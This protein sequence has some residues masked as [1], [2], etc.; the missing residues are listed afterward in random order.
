MGPLYAFPHSEG[1]KGRNHNFF[2]PPHTTHALA[3]SKGTGI[4]ECLSS[5]PGHV[6]NQFSFSEIFS[7][8]WKKAMIPST[9]SSG[10]KA[11]GVF[12]FNRAAV[13][14]AMDKKGCSTHVL[15]F[16]FVA[17]LPVDKLMYKQMSLSL[18]LQKLSFNAFSVGTNKVLTLQVTLDFESWDDDSLLARCV[19]S[20]HDP[21][22]VHHTPQP[23][24]TCTG[25]KYSPSPF[26]LDTY[27]GED[28]NSSRSMYPLTEGHGNRPS[29]FSQD[30][31]FPG[32]TGGVPCFQ[33]PSG[34]AHQFYGNPYLPNN[35]C[36][37]FRGLQSTFYDDINDE[38]CLA[39]YG[40]VISTSLSILDNEES[41]TTVQGEVWLDEYS[42]PTRP[43]RVHT[44]KCNVS[45]VSEVE[46]EQDELFPTV[47]D[48]V[49]S[50]QSS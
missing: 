40:E 47:Q 5:N 50:T 12:P 9:I 11:T 20:P 33:Y 16:P 26:Y 30:Y 39:R 25:L 1:C 36:H 4:E 44:D 22:L 35:W 31:Y 38:P 19:T 48:R 32:E 46:E 24:E 17:H 15:L 3:L 27:P 42:I 37:R 18:T 13:K 2:L 34:Q 10:F 43:R 14:L 21:Y 49:R 7:K 28:R 41:S 6:I 23:V 29:S 45:F 8:S